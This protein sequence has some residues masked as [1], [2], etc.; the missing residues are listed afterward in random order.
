MLCSEGLYIVGMTGTAPTPQREDALFADQKMEGV[1]SIGI[2]QAARPV[3]DDYCNA[4]TEFEVPPPTA[5]ERLLWKEDYS[6]VLSSPIW[7]QRDLRLVT[8]VFNPAR[9][10]ELGSVI[11]DDM[12]PHEALIW[13]KDSDELKSLT[14]LSGYV[15]RDKA[16]HSWRSICDLCGVRAEFANAEP[17]GVGIGTEEDGS[18]WR[19]DRTVH[20]DIDGPGG[21]YVDAIYH[22]IHEDPVAVRVSL[23][24]CP[25]PQMC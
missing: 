4:P 19:E 2:I 14:R 7:A 23:A 18:K 8:K 22:A 21:E 16:D 1:A 3:G 5:F 25:K 20:F 10:V 11:S 9:K 13:G 17:R 24:H 12:V 15:V 6:N